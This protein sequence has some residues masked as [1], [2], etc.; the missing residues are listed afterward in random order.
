MKVDTPSKMKYVKRNFTPVKNK[1][2]NKVSNAESHFEKLLINSPI[3]FFREKGNFRWD[4]RWCYYD[5]YI[6]Y[7]RLY[8]EIDGKEH[9][10]P[11]K[12]LIDNEKKALVRDNHY[13]L[14]RFTNEEVLDLDAIDIM[15]I[16]DKLCQQMA[17]PKNPNEDLKGK[18]FRTLKWNRKK[19]I[20]D[21]I[22]DAVFDVDKS[23]KVY[24]Y[25]HR[26]GEYFEFKNIIHAKLNTQLSVNHIY[27]L[28]NGFEYKKSAIRRYVFGWSLD[29]CENNVAKVYY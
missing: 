12:V 4:T 25:D 29:E 19:A 15:E 11:E 6:P 8:I 1:L 7:Y 13:Y 16:I 20:D 27:K 23:K 10:L 18:F 9:N 21:M 17:N 26:I 24:L 28:L 5:F 2:L 14:V 22:R 3:Y